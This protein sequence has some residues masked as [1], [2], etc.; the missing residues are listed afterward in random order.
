MFTLRSSH[1]TLHIVF[2]LRQSTCDTETKITHVDLSLNIE[3]CRSI[4][5]KKMNMDQTGYI[6]YFRSIGEPPKTT[7]ASQLSKTM[8]MS[9]VNKDCKIRVL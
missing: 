4:I 1:F 3:V 6:L 8:V 2:T 9:A 7:N 5:F